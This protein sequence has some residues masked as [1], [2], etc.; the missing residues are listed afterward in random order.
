MDE[1]QNNLPPV[2]DPAIG[3]LRGQIQ[4]LANMVEALAERDQPEDR[5]HIDI[6]GGAGVNVSKVGNTFGVD[7]AFPAQPGRRYCVAQADWTGSGTLS[8]KNIGPVLSNASPP[9]PQSVTSTAYDVSVIGSGTISKGDVLE[10]VDLVESDGA[11]V[12]VITPVVIAA[13]VTF[14][15]IDSSVSAG[16]NRWTYTGHVVTKGAAGYGTWANGAALT[17]CIFNTMEECYGTTPYNNGAS[18]SD[19]A[20]LGN[21]VTLQPIPATVVVL[22]QTVINSAGGVEYW[23]TV[24]NGFSVTCGG[25]A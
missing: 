16:T 18:A 7:V 5:E 22:C 11:T 25:G 9:V 12:P 15:R 20:F 6:V 21:I 23:F 8:V 13:K 19:G 4:E 24:P 10:V 17:S 2:E 14:V 1:K 3:E